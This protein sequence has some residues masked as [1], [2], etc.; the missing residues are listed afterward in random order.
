MTPPEAPLVE[1]V[2][3]PEVLVDGFASASILN[4]VARLTF[5]SVRHDPVTNTHY[6]LVNLRMAL[7]LAA[8]AGVHE[9]LGRMLEEAR[10][11]E[12]RNAH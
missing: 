2:P 11:M 8:A 5:F 10:Q 7:P 4:G 6:R 12:T 9:A 1:P 3:A